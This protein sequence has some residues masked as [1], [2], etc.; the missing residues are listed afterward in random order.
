MSPTYPQSEGGCAASW[1]EGG[2]GPR[3]QGALQPWLVVFCL[4]LSHM[5][6]NEPGYCPTEAGGHP[7]LVRELGKPQPPLCVHR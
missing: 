5:C 2:P 3:L 4:S 7:W 1:R 6:M